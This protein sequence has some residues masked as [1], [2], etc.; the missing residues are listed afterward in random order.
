MPSF[1]R[2]YAISLPVR[3]YYFQL[4]LLGILLVSVYLDDYVERM[5]F[6][7]DIDREHRYKAIYEY[8]CRSFI[9]GKGG[10]KE[11]S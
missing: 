10:G 4:C 2:K 3:K 1:G 5:E 7:C 9:C 11:N 6:F 8:I